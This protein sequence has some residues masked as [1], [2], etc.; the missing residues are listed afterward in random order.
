[1][2]GKRK[3]SKIQTVTYQIGVDVLAFPIYVTHVISDKKNM[4]HGYN[5]R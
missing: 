1:M 3:R 4:K 2:R 5:Y